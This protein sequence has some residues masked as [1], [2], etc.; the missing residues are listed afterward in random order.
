MSHDAASTARYIRQL[1]L[2]EISTQNQ[3][4]LASSRILCVGAGGLAASAL[5]YLAGAGVSHITIIDHDQIALSNLHR[6]VF[7]TEADIGQNKAVVLVRRL[8]A[9]NRDSKVIANNSRLTT[10]NA[11]ILIGE[12]DIVIDCTDNYRAKYVI[13][14]YCYLLGIPWVYASV[15]QWSG[16]CAL[17][18][19]E[20]GCY[21]CLYPE[22]VAVKNCSEAGVLGTTPGL[23]GQLQALEALKLLLDLPLDLSAKN[24]RNLLL[25]DT[26]SLSMQKIRRAQDP[27]CKLCCQKLS[28]GILHREY[29]EQEAREMLPKDFWDLTKRSDKNNYFLLDVRSEAEHAKNNIGG[30]LVPLNDL[31]RYFEL[32]ESDK[33]S[34]PGN[35]KYLAN[36]NLLLDALH[37]EKPVII[38]CRSGRRSAIAAQA[39][40]QHGNK[41][42][43]SLL[44]GIG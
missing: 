19:G 11:E 15:D 32:S 7:F 5:P 31:L 9:L 28:L 20:Q 21:R 38:Y 39:L 23:L 16:Q 29:A 1:A 26:L 34:E 42:I 41:N 43:R 12:H 35:S 2:P 27:H 22:P 24:H 36:I 8:Q 3:I 14:D 10:S 18:D 40:L 6:Q 13:N 4:A 44:G 17:F 33:P 30:V 37:I 25:F